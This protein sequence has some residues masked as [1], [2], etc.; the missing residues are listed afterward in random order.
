MNILVS[1]LSAN[2]IISD[3]EQLFS[4]Y[5]RV[6]YANIVRDKKSGRSKGTAFLEMPNEAEGEQAILAL[7]H[8]VVDGIIQSRISRKTTQCCIKGKLTVQS[9]YSYRTL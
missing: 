4:V 5:G 2:I 9:E 7:N 6:S 8:Q 3:L 1:N